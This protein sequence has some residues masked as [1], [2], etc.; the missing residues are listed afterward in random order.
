VSLSGFLLKKSGLIFKNPVA[1]LIKMI[2]VQR[3]CVLMDPYSYL[4]I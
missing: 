2:T 1:T 4:L 3:N